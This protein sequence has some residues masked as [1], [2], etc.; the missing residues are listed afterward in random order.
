MGRV[1]D[2]LGM[3]REDALPRECR[4]WRRQQVFRNSWAG[5]EHGNLLTAGRV[6][7]MDIAVPCVNPENRALLRGAENHHLL[8]IIRN[9]GR[10]R[11]ESDCSI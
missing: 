5:I 2:A 9:V 1:R 11:L 3:G 8:Y 6:N 4:R 7:D 10:P